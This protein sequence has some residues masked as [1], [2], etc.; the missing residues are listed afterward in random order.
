MQ[1]TIFLI[2]IL[3][4][5]KLFFS[6][7]QCVSEK[8][9]LTNIHTCLSLLDKTEDEQ[10]H[11]QQHF[12]HVFHGSQEGEVTNN[13]NVSNNQKITDILLNNR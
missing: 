7:C 4:S 12:S 9:I 5:L 11:Y 13:S 1:K 3:Y 10:R 2:L 8:V 6:D